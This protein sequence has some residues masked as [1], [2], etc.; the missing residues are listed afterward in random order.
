VFPA[1]E[2]RP[3]G[4]D[5]PRKGEDGLQRAKHWLESSTRVKQA[6]TASEV[7][8]G[9]FCHFEW[10]CATGPAKPFSFDLGGNF[11][12]GALENKSFLAEIKKYKAEQDLPEEYRK[13]AAKCYVALGHDPVLCDNFLWISWAPFQA[14]RWDEHATTDSV[15]E[16]LK[17][18]DNRKRLFDVDTAEEAALKL[19][20]AL[21]ADVARRIW[22]ITLCDQQE[23]LVLMPDHYYT[24]KGII[25]REQGQRR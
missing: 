17:H 12:G 22:L 2:N 4:E 6:W 21:A 13:F 16:A 3:P 23:Q 20:K 15:C 5:H 18:K 9:R 14:Q 11:R 8:C 19:D 24:I 10:P 7:P 1:H 25:D